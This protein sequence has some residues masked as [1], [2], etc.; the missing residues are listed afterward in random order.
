MRSTWR[1]KVV[2][3]TR[4]SASNT[5]CLVVAAE[6]G[7]QCQN[8]SIARPA[9]PALGVNAVI[10]NGAGRRLTQ[11]QIYQRIPLKQIPRRRL[12]LLANTSTVSRTT[13]CSKSDIDQ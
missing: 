8:A 7:T 1:P 9:T 2:R 10:G 11:Q 13:D 5:A 4:G 3:D 6:L 12:T